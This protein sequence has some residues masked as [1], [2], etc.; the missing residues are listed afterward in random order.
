MLRPKFPIAQE[1]A[2]DE[3]N[4]ILD[5]LLEIAIE[6]SDAMERSAFFKPA[7]AIIDV[8]FLSI[9]AATGVI[10]A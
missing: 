1:I 2:E 10:F 6:I 5:I 9:M 3:S 7:G 4:T 8:I